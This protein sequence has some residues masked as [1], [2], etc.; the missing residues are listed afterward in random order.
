MRAAIA[1]SPGVLSE[2]QI[3]QLHHG[4]VI[5]CHNYSLQSDASAFDLRISN[6]AWKLEE[7]QRPSTRELAKIQAKSSEIK[8]ESDSDGEYFHFKK[9]QIYL[10]ELDH[11]LKLPMNINGRATGKSSIGR[12]DVICRLLTENSTEYDIVEAG[13][14]GHLYLLVLPQT[15][16]IKIKPGESLNQLRLFSGAPYASV[17]TRSVIHDFGTPFWY[18][19]R[20]DRPSEWIAWEDLSAEYSNSRTADPTLFDLTVDLADAGWDYIYKA[21]P[22][23][24]DPIDLRKGKGSHDPTAYFEKK[25]IEQYGAEHSALLE[26]GSFYIMK[27]KERL[28]IPI[29]V[30]V[31]VIAISERIGDIR[32]HYAG[33]AHPG[34][35][36]HSD[37]TKFGTP[38]IF[39]VRATDMLT[40]LYDKS[41]LA[42]V[43][44]FRM[45]EKAE[46]KKSEYDRQEMK[47]SSV[48]AE[49]KD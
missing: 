14:E 42:R 17:I 23:A 6:R 47:L 5:I 39:E 21:N 45:S 49:W 22:D 25:P 18:V 40:R 16:S 12:L 37:A 4:S 35:G 19:R 26:Q 32:I 34:F 3:M 44:L 11:Y 15:F 46:P 29:D 30:A 36:Q 8:L 27:S 33:F 10:V 31:E 48:F 38:L 1:M 7:G 20:E 43:Q 24:K 2:T 28:C 9:E 13:Y 41:L